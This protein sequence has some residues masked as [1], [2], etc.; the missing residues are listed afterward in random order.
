MFSYNTKTE[1]DALVHFLTLSK[2]M[3]NHCYHDVPGKDGVL[4]ID[5]QLAITDAQTEG[6]FIDHYSK[7]PIE[8]LPWKQDRPQK[9]ATNY[10]CV[11]VNVEAK[12]LNSKYGEREQAEIWDASCPNEKCALCDLP[13]PAVK[14]KVRG[15]CKVG[16]LFDKEYFYYILENGKQAYLGKQS[17]LISYD[18]EEKLWSW[19]D[20]GDSTSRGN[21]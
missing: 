18:S 21:I 12:Q 15:L 13:T 9:K 10:N 14:I 2:N 1:F 4:S 11:L 5:A 3:K 8:Y 20:A 16:S 7:E 19:T 6:S 17:S